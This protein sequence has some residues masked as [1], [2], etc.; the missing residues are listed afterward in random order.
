MEAK[1]ESQK[2]KQKWKEDYEQRPEPHTTPAYDTMHFDFILQ[3]DTKIYLP[4]AITNIRLF[5]WNFSLDSAVF[6]QPFS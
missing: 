2:R 4:Q 3:F 5:G 6:N 1:V